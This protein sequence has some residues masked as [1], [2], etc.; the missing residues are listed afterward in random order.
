MKFLGIISVD[1]DE[2]DELLMKYSSFVIRHILDER[3][4]CLGL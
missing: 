1:F 3:W 4:E 2:T